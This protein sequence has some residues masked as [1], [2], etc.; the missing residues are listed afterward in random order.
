MLF[1]NSSVFFFRQLIIRF[2]AAIGCFRNHRYHQGLA[3]TL[4]EMSPQNITFCMEA[5][6]KQSQGNPHMCTTLFIFNQGIYLSLFHTQN[7]IYI[8]RTNNDN[9]LV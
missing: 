5:P 4:A 6:H 7:K 1:L 2:L 8:Q 3:L 9:S